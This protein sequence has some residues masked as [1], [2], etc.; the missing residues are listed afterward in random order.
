MK[1]KSVFSADAVVSQIRDARAVRSRRRTWGKSRLHKHL[2]EI[3]KLR[4]AGATYVDLQYWLRKEKRVKIDR[5]NIMRFI[6]KHFPNP[7]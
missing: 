1:L 3:V 7:D 6:K 2:A 5:S 4:E